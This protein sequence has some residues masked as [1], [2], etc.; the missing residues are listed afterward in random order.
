MPPSKSRKI[1]I[2]GY[3]S[4]GK[5]SLTIQ[6]VEGQFVDSYDPTIENTFTKLITVNGQEYHLQLVD[7]AGQDEYS[8]FPQTYSIDINGYILVYSVT[9]IKRIPIM[10]VGNKK[11]LHMERVISYEEGK[12]LAESW[13][14]A[15]LESSAKENQTAV[16]V[17]R[18]IILEAE[19]IDGAASQGKSSCLVM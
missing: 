13:N 2:L 17:F 15:F 8:I 14:A 11:D 4:V 18:R 12:A 10:L 1:A 5:S 3:R 16:D 19:K 6:F 7:T 9:S